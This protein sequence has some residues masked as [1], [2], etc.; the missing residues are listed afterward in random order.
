MFLRRLLFVACGVGAGVALVATLSVNI[1]LHWSEEISVLDAPQEQVAG[2][3]PTQLNDKLLSG[4]LHLKMVSGT[5]KAV[6]FLTR[7]P[8]MLA[9]S[10]AY[11]F[12]PS[13]IAAFLGG[14]LVSGRRAA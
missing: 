9:Y 12:V 4:A 5:E 8:M 3:T 2:L 7:S 1:L 14:L 13:A 10:W 6:Y 11:F